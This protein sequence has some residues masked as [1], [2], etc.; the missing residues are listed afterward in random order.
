M[1][2]RFP[3]ATHAT[4]CAY[5]QPNLIP[6]VSLICERT[7]R[8]AERQVVCHCLGLLFLCG[9]LQSNILDF[10]TSCKRET[11]YS[12]GLI[13]SIHIKRLENKNDSESVLVRVS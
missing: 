5:H 4:H 3:L 13:C 8:M 6:I 12:V 10:D 1:G 9:Y 7:N 2:P 11:I